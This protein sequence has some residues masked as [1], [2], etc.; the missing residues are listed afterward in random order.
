MK[1]L[2][3]VIGNSKY[4]NDGLQN[5]SNDAHDFS[6]ILKRL[7]FITRKLVDATI[8]LQDNAI[9]K[10]GTDLDDY[11]VGLFYFAG[12]GFQIDGE[13]FLTA[14]D[15]RFNLE[16]SVKYSST[17]LNKILSLM[18]KAKNSTNIIILDACRD[19]PY[20]KKWSRGSGSRGLA[21]IYAPKGTI[22]AF[23]TSPGE[24]AS[25]G[26]GRNGLFTSALLR[27]ITDQKI[28]IEELF[29]RVRNSV[30]AFSNGKQTSWE[31]TSLS[32]T[33]Y[34]NYGQLVHM[35]DT[36]YREEA[37]IDEKYESGVNKEPIDEI[38]ISLK[39]HNWYAQNPSI[40]EIENLKPETEDRSK[41][42]ILGR[43][44]L[45]AAHGS[46][47]NAQFF[48][49]NLNENAK[50]FTIDGDN[51]LINGILFEIYFDSK[52]KFR[53]IDKLKDTCLG[54]VM[55]IFNSNA[56]SKSIEF[57]EKQLEPYLDELF[58]IPTLS[59]K[60]IHFELLLSEKR[61]EKGSEYEVKSISYEGK[62]II[63]PNL[64]FMGESLLEPLLFFRFKQRMERLTS[65]PE[66][67][68]KINA[69]YD[70]ED[71]SRILFPYG[72]IIAKN[73]KSFAN[74]SF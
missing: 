49:E 10:F 19:N 60:P 13:N 48:I 46:A 39:S 56:Y 73:V 74:L 38:I 63:S 53:G 33:Y 59:Q 21:P 22:I 28:P 71:N 37:I 62:S 1:S 35:V 43:N 67:Y 47:N 57:I 16:D 30:Y 36:P 11:E 58:F 70:I 31:H 50:A 45:Q 51:D 29:K 23:A 65:V 15:T 32:G 14:I 44:I 3:L 5:A 52:G 72:A 17:P 64:D 34:F 55:K 41:L 27:H 66:K 40:K 2:A 61:S 4:P 8:E 24:R 9:E 68:M 6:E 42:F 18:D 69:N 7:G 54:D 25:D 20:E 26:I 12:H